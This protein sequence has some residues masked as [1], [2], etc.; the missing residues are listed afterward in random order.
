LLKPPRRTGKRKTLK[1]SSHLRHLP[2]GVR[3]KQQSRQ[4]SRQHSIKPELA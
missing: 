1:I 4:Q 2:Q 3:Q